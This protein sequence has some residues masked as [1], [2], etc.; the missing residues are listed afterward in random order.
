[1]LSCP[2]GWLH[3]VPAYCLELT[4]YEPGSGMVCTLDLG[5][6]GMCDVAYA[7]DVPWDTW[8]PPPQSCASNICV[9]PMGLTI[10]QNT[11]FQHGPYA[12]YG[13]Y[14]LPDLVITRS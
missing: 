11:Y 3:S 12:R 8:S 10:Y 6:A 4:F 2:G 1:M 14:V 9:N 13:E 7:V 5:Q